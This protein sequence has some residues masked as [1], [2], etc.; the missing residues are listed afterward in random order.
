MIIFFDLP[1]V[2][3]GSKIDIMVGEK[4][5]IYNMEGQYSD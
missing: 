4:G 2:S 1:E 3:Q 5:V